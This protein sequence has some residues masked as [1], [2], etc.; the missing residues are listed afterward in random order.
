MRAYHITIITEHI[1]YILLQTKNLSKKIK[2]ICS[3]FHGIAEPWV[4][5]TPNTL[6]KFVLIS[7]ELLLLFCE[8]RM[9]SITTGLRF[10][11]R[12]ASL[13][14][15]FK[16]SFYNSSSLNFFSGSLLFLMWN[17]T[18]LP[19]PR[20]LQDMIPH[21]CSHFIL[22]HCTPGPSSCASDILRD[23]L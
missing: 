20:G 22:C 15:P 18:H 13:T 1:P 7:K 14:L 12:Y 17:S 5:R 10:P 19:D 8:R 11:F 4:P 16:I 23:S 21:H 9:L 2:H 3:P 6:F